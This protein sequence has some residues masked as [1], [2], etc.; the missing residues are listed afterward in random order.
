MLVFYMHALLKDLERLCKP[1]MAQKAAGGT[2][3]AKEQADGSARLLIFVIPPKK[4]RILVVEGEVM[5]D[6]VRSIDTSASLL[7][8]RI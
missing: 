5:R 6:V 1:R 3:R 4:E 8:T 2:R 7:T